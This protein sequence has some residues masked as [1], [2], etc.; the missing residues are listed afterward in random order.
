MKNFQVNKYGYFTEDG[1]EFVI[2]TPKT[3]APWMNYIWNGRWA[4]LVSH[5]GGGYSFYLTPRD[6]RFTSHISMS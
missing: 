5:T 6:N 1:K 2:T 3:P 4:G